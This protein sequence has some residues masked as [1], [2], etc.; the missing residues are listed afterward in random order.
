MEP[1]LTVYQRHH[2]RV[3]FE[4][5]A[6]HLYGPMVHASKA[7]V[8]MLAEQGLIPAAS[9]TQLL[10]GCWC[11]T[12]TGPRSSGTTAAS[13]TCTTPWSGAWP[14]PAASAPAS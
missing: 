1:N 11:S 7:H 2:L 14:R 5:H 3:A 6:A 4:H 9:A 13:R 12:A 10:R 8:V